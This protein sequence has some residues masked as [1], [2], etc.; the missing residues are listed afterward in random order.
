MESIDSILKHEKKLTEG[1][2]YANYNYSS[3]L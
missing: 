3:S 1:V 2:N